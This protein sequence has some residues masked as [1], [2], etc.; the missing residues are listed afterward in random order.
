MRN[1]NLLS[2]LALIL[3]L[4][5]APAAAQETEEAVAAYVDLSI[6]R[7]ELALE[8]LAQEGRMPEAE[9][10]AVFLAQHG[11]DAWSYYSFAAKHPK[12]LADYLESHPEKAETIASLSQQIDDLM[13]AVEGE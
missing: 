1:L 3:F 12:A 13:P 2:I 9:E 7:L 8:T 11:T 5:A 10:E 6:A 4:A